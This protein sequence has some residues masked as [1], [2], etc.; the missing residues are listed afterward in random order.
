M[1][2]NGHTPWSGSVPTTV[3]MHQF[4]I[5]LSISFYYSLYLSF[6][7]KDYYIPFLRSF[8]LATISFSPITLKG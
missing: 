8:R 6:Y 7:Y 5:S 3:D 1:W 2:A 4:F